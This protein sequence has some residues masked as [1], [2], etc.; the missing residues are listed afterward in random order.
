[1]TF[2]FF[3]SQEGIT[4]DEQDLSSSFK[5]ETL[6]ALESTTS[7]TKKNNVK[8]FS[9]QTGLSKEANAA[10]LKNAYFRTK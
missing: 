4:V 6:P 8:F 9:F 3:L 7:S 2:S 1:M 10:S 5:E